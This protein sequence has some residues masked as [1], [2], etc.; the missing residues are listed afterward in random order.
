MGTV[1]CFCWSGPLEKAT[2]DNGDNKVIAK[3]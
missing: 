3:S 1:K 2:V